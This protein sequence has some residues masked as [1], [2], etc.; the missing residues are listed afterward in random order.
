MPLDINL[1]TF[2]LAPR[3]R[4]PFVTT[5]S[6]SSNGSSPQATYV[7]TISTEEQN[8]YNTTLHD[9]FVPDILYASI[10]AR[11]EIHPSSAT[12]PGGTPA[13][14]KVLL[15]SEFAISLFNPDST[16]ILEHHHSALRGTYWEFSL[17]KTSFLPPT[18]SKLDAA[19][20]AA[21]IAHLPR[22]T[23][24][25]R[26][27]GGIM[28]RPQLRCSLV[29]P[30]NLPSIPGTA[31]AS[32]KAGA[33]EPDIPIAMFL[34]LGEKKGIGEITIIQSNLKR[35]EVED[36]KGLEVVLLLSAMAIGDIWFQSTNQMFNL[37]PP[38]RGS[39]NGTARRKNSMPL[40][41]A[42][43][44]IAVSA[45]EPRSPPTTSPQH[46]KPPP[47][48]ASFAARFQQQQQSHQRRHST[49]MDADAE[50]SR[51]VQEEE[52]RKRR[53][54]EKE[55]EEIRKMLA[56]EESRERRK[57]E[58]DINRET[59]RLK[60][61]YEAERAEYMARGAR[62]AAQPQR[63]S[64]QQRNQR[65]PVVGGSGGMMM[66]PP[67]GGRG[68]AANDEKKLGS[69][70]SFLGLKFGSSSSSK[71]EEKKKK[72]SKKGSSMF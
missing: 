40:A 4:E 13:D 22:A 44:T 8:A 11:P 43:P 63:V 17:P 35:V 14:P 18:S 24:R 10:N 59:E 39:A 36:L 7:K 69:R 67:Q 53:I 42:T 70:K 26:K 68:G 72:L 31:S 57:R 66:P 54:A 56:E 37:N 71:E 48:D 25:W 28:T 60:R 19:S 34:G 16:T 5:L 51:R 12:S 20:A 52:K 61:I 30:A 9:A 33:N 27:E 58:E 41:A 49:P 55:Q 2:H 6:Y 46:G 65:P 50:Y 23:F 21:A 1:P 47:N 64:S 15:P 38:I 29:S 62:N 45:P 32:K 3:P